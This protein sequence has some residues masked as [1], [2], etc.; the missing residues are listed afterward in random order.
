MGI[1]SGLIKKGYTVQPFKTGPDYI[2]PGYLSMISN[3]R[4]QNLD[5]WLMGKNKILSVF[6]KYSLS[7]ISIIE[8][9]MGYYDGMYA[10]S[11]FAT[12]FHISTILNSPVVLILDAS[13]TA[14]SIAATALGYI[15]FHKKSNISGFILN[16]LSSKRH[17]D[18]CVNALKKLNLPVLGSIYNDDRLFLHNRHLGLIPAMEN[19]LL[20][21]KIKRTAN[22]ISSMIDI[23]KIIKI[24][25]KSTKLNINK[26]LKNKKT[27]TTIAVALD[28]SFNFYY[29]DSINALQRDGA[30][31]KYF[32][33]LFDTKLPECD[34]IY[35]GGGFPEIFAQLLEKNNI[36]K[37]IKK[38]AE[39]NVPI[40][41][42]CGGLMYL[43]NSIFYNNKK[44]S[45]VKL[46]DADT[47][48]NTKITLGYVKGNIISN[49][50]L[51]S[52]FKNIRGHEFH[53][54]QIK[55]LKKDVKFAY[56]LS[57]GKGIKNKRDG[58]ILYNALAS[59]IHLYLDVSNFT[60]TFIKKCIFYS[61]R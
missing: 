19:Q 39:T 44:Y 1:I 59:Y 5:A 48:M 49:C 45:M 55:N 57:K 61:K 30:Q 43:T 31:I 56:T 42:E 21:N 38:A 22:K 25:M 50:L 52:S 9:V 13:K 18:I 11:N 15:K 3:N 28:T 14:R 53:Y 51:S 36:K 35:F 20:S 17:N 33:P 54:S 60:K 58:L 23:D 46:F 26:P 24:C 10:H 32:S 12:T 4:A 40:Y 8:G 34:G 27:K 2:D 6:G 47:I 16:R 41:A 7:D 29:F 37:D